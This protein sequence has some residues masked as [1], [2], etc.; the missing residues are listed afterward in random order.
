MHVTLPPVAEPSCEHVKP[1]VGSVVADRNFVPAGSVSRT[2]I[3]ALSCVPTLSTMIVYVSVPLVAI[4][5][6]PSVSGGA[7]PGGSTTPFF[8][9]SPFQTTRSM[10]VEMPVDSVAVLLVSSA[11]K[12]ALFG[13]TVTVFVI[14][15]TFG[16]AT[17]T[18]AI[19]L[20]DEAGS[21]R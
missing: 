16:G 18:N 14:E 3:P 2:L 4:G 21:T 19:F 11:S 7:P 20:V 15:P 17:S 9:P 12:I 5:S 10:P 6:K 8:P 13:S 1:W